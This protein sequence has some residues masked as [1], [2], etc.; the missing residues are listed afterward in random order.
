M[1]PLYPPR[2]LEKAKL[3][4][5]DRDGGGGGIST[6]LILVLK[7]IVFIKTSATIRRHSFI[8]KKKSKPLLFMKFLLCA[9]CRGHLIALQGS[10][11]GRNVAERARAI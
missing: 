4:Y 5:Y 9:R 2:A 11:T 8:K 7:S 1:I 6:H 3:L 10:Y